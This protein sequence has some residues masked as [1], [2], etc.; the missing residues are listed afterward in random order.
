MGRLPSLGKAQKIAV[1][2]TVR[3]YPSFKQSWNRSVISFARIG[4]AFLMTRGGASSTL[5][6]V[7]P[8][9]NIAS[10]TSLLEHVCHSMVQSRD[11]MSK[12]ASPVVELSLKLCI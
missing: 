4:Q 9:C 11:S 3:W 2:K 12:S 10:S 6:D 1:L 5:G 7:L 8:A